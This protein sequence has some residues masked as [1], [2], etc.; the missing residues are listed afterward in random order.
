[1]AHI[2]GEVGLMLTLKK[3]G[4]AAG[5]GL[6][7]HQTCLRDRGGGEWLR[8]GDGCVQKGSRSR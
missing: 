6:T 4:R 2:G 3:K 5:E 1:M 8:D 7:L